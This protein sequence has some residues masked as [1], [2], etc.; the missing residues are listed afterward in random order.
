[1]YAN[2]ASIATSSQECYIKF[3]CL[4]PKFDE[5]G[6]VVSSGELESCQVIMNR[7]MMLKLRDMITDVFEKE[8]A[9]K[10]NINE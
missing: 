4:G 8:V 6:H 10:I 1:M 7:E 3:S 2:K 9:G 5:E